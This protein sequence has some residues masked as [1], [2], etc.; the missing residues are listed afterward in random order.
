MLSD[1]YS[2]AEADG[3]KYFLDSQRFFLSQVPG[4][5]ALLAKIVQY[6]ASGWPKD[7]AFVTKYGSSLSASYSTDICQINPAGGRFCYNPMPYDPLCIWGWIDHFRSMVSGTEFQTD[8]GLL[9][10]FDQAALAAISQYQQQ[11]NKSY[12]Q[13]NNS[14]DISAILQ[15]I[16]PQDVTQQ[17]ATGSTSGTGTTGSSPGTGTTGTSPAQPTTI[18]PVVG[19]IPTNYLYYGAAAVAAYFLFIKRRAA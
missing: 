9:V 7:W 16:H 6:D 1:A 3:N 13:M 17:P 11:T 18:L 19:A 8:E 5:Q 10:S 2:T 4:Y 15:I 12:S 14:A